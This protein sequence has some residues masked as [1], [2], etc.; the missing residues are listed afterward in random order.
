MTEN[1]MSTLTAE[2]AKVIVDLLTSYLNSRSAVIQ[3]QK[4]SKP[5]A[6]L[7]VHL[8]GRA[9][10][11]GFAEYIKTKHHDPT[12]VFE[13]LS[14]ILELSS[15]IRAGGSKSCLYR[16]ETGCSISP[17]DF[18]DA[19]C[20]QLHYTYRDGK[21]T[22]VEAPSV[23]SVSLLQKLQAVNEADEEIVQQLQSQIDADLL[24]LAQKLEGLSQDSLL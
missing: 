3:M 19:V 7:P 5:E 8:D 16:L 11:V 4:D 17:A 14:H 1:A 20:D 10:M 22:A 2:S 23:T 24:T 12:L 18:Y 9:F 13:G 6:G 21:V 15:F